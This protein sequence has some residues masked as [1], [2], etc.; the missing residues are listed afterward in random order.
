MCYKQMRLIIL[1]CNMQGRTQGV[2]GGL[3]EPCILIVQFYFYCNYDNL[4][5]VIVQFYFIVK[6]NYGYVNNLCS[7]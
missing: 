6:L 1:W 4:I 3:Y 5:M 7:S 2:R